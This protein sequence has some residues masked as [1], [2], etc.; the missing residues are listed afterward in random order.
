MA[1]AFD[2]QACQGT[3]GAVTILTAVLA[4]SKVGFFFVFF[5]AVFFVKFL[6]R[7][8]GARAQPPHSPNEEGPWGGSTAGQY[9]LYAS[10]SG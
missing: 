7:A 2:V 10:C 4:I 5:P 8:T 9:S 6:K 3:V 1:E